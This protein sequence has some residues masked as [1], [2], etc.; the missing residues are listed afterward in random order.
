MISKET[1]MSLPIGR[2]LYHV[3]EKNADGTPQ[4]WRVNGKCKT[5]KTNDDWKLPIKHAMMEFSYLT[6][7][8]YEK[9]SED[10]PL[11]CN[12]CG[13][14]VYFSCSVFVDKRKGYDSMFCTRCRKE[15]KN[16]SS[17]S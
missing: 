9:L 3:S 6:Q 5:W 1:A 14:E 12:D 10:F 15:R 13:N 16:D 11:Y 2:E 4:R 7:D 8:N 17:N